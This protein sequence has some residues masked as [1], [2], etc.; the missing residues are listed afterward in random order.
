[1]S[2]NLKTIKEI[3]DEIGV[4]KQQ[5]PLLADLIH[6]Q[7]IQQKHRNFSYLS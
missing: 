4:S 3:A 5:V 6:V 1:M 7:Y 2:E